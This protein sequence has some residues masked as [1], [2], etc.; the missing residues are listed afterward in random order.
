MPNRTSSRL[1]RRD[2]KKKIG[3]S[4][5]AF[6]SPF[7]SCFV[8]I[9]LRLPRRPTGP[10]Q[11]GPK[12]SAAA[13]SGSRQQLLDAFCKFANATAPP[14]FLLCCCAKESESEHARSFCEYIAKERTRRDGR[15]QRLPLPPPGEFCAKVHLLR[16]TAER[17]H[18]GRGSSSSAAPR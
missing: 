18:G 12:R 17:R 3:I 9:I 14:P 13:W 7:L 5:D 16:T 6:S 15:P 8:Y 11:H 1:A 4:S 10:C 2:E